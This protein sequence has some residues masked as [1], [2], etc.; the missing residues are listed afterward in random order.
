MT[1]IALSL[2]HSNPYRD[3]DLHPL[4][5][6]QVDR[7][8]ASIDAD[9]FWASVV[10]RKIAD[11][12]QIAYGHHRVEAAKDLGWTHVPIEVRE[13]SDWQMINM[14]AS[15]NATQRGSTA[16][17]ALDAVAALCKGLA[18]NLL[19][20]EDEATFFRNMGKVG[21]NS[22]LW[23]FQYASCRGRLESGSGIGRDCILGCPP[24]D[25]FT[26]YQVDAALGQLKDSG[27][28]TAIIADARSRVDAELRAEQEAAERALA[29]AQQ[30]EAKAKTKR[31][32]EAAAKETNK[33]KKTVAKG[34]KSSAARG[35][36]VA[37]A[38]RRPV[39]YDARCAQLFKFE[40]H[41]E[42]FRQIITGETFQAYLKL[43][44][45]FAF[46][47]SVI[48][49]LRENMPNKKEITAQDIRAECWS[50]IETGLGMS[51]GKMRTA[52]E[53]PYLEEIKEGLNLL[54]RA[55]GDFKR[56]VALLIRGF[57]LG[58]RLDA[59]QV[60][61]LNAIEATFDA[62]WDG[63]KPYRQAKP[64]LKLVEGE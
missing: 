29:E 14:L 47:K 33:A 54:R 37:S 6:A 63:M 62:G 23:D 2:I 38:E 24:K 40:S 46:A 60:E 3:F 15:E 41:A 21:E 8:K 17:A 43:D 30:R 50:R 7:L 45:Q 31:E 53:R 34:A 55:E 20:W 22:R 1:D 27:R 49:A 13:L 57:S 16:A 42:T 11:G 18:Y 4:D 51:K 52:P 25:R 12:Y 48:A 32:R 19:R 35:K 5:K 61:R 10:A 39:I 56:G 9:G 26:S 36:A 59:K 64:N 58:E 28:L 44:Q